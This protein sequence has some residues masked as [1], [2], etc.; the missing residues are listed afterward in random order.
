MTSSQSDLLAQL[1]AM[2]DDLSIEEAVGAFYLEMCEGN[3]E[4]AAALY[5]EQN[6]EPVPVTSPLSHLLV[7]KE[8]EEQEVEPLPLFLLP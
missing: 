1:R 7:L 6:P 2:T 5:R 3:V 4:R 8:E